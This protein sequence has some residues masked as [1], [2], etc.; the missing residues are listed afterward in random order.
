MGDRDSVGIV[1]LS[2]GPDTGKAVR[3]QRTVSPSNVANG[4]IDRYGEMMIESVPA[5]AAWIGNPPPLSQGEKERR[6]QVMYAFVTATGAI[7]QRCA[8]GGL[9]AC[10]VALN[11]RHIEGREN[12][13]RYS[14]FVRT[15]LLY[16]ALDA[17]GTGSWSRLRAAADSGVPAMLGAAARMPADSVI[18]RWRGNLLELRPA[19]AVL[20]PGSAILSAT[21]VGILLLGA[22]GA[23]KWA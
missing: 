21:W 20:T 9:V 18:A 2:G 23:S 12:G 8:A 22:L 11:I 6:D 17:G 14:P 1:M 15:D 16:F 4:L 13:G 7:Q 3:T 5:L 10:H 19:T